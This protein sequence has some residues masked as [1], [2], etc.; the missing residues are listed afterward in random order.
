LPDDLNLSN[1]PSIGLAVD[2]PF[3]LGWPVRELRS[4]RG[5][6]DDHACPFSHGRFKGGTMTRRARPSRL[7][8][9]LTLAL[10]AIMITAI[11]AQ[12]ASANSLLTCTGTGLSTFSP[13]LTYEP[14]EVEA[15]FFTDYTSC[16]DTENLKFRTGS[17]TARGTFPELV[18]SDELL[19]ES[20]GASTIHWSTG[21]SS[22]WEWTI[23][24]VK[25]T[26]GIVEAILEGAITGGE[27]AGEEAVES[28]TSTDAEL[29]A[30]TKPGGLKSVSSE[31]VFQIL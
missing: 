7:A 26:G 3:I 21:T 17:W 24:E 12:T 30:C 19:D 5:A 23:I 31:V 16:L 22:E 15:T 20:V 1:V 6:G 9:F 2:Q 4:R 18:C 11:F 27:F 28:D 25:V 8:C 13:G 29:D 14:Q 10:G